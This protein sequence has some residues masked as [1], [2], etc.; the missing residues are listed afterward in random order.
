MNVYMLL[1]RSGSMSGPKWVETLGSVNGY[2]EKLPTAAKVHLVAFDSVGHD[3][4]RET[5]AGKWRDV[6]NEEVSPRGGTPLFDSAARVLNK[7][8]GDDPE[9]AV[10]VILTD[11]EENGSKEV[12][13]EGVKALVKRTEEKGWEVVFMGAN[14]DVS[15]QAASFGKGFDKFMMATPGNFADTT[16]MM[17]MHT[18]SY[19]S[20]ESASMNFTAED[21]ANAV[22]F[23]TTPTAVK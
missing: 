8:L 15:R 6:T 22:K 9:R 12:T 16:R 2:V 17:A 13:Q 5:T 21:K 1:D 18:S 14:F 7:A 10:I 11:G 4:L 20:G 23:R 19:L 3:V